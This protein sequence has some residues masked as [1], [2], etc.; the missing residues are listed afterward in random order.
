MVVEPIHYCQSSN[1]RTERARN[2]RLAV[3]AWK[4][5]VEKCSDHVYSRDY[6]QGFEEGYADYL[7]AGGIGAPPPLPPR[8]YWRASYQTPEGRQ[9]TTDWFAGFHHGAQEAQQSGYR[10]LIIVPASVPP[11]VTSGSRP[12]VI[13]SGPP[14]ES[15]GNEP[16]TG[17]LSY[18]P[19]DSLPPAELG[20]PAVT[21]PKEVAPPP[22]LIDADGIPGP[23]SVPPVPHAGHEDNRT[24]S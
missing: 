4:S 8:R 1:E 11:P 13:F 15:T 17:P 20:L 16:V 3:A 14:R 7:F 24:G 9:A 19:G 6:A 2:H 18:I 21:V 10:Q 22:R 12:N 23:E 5:V